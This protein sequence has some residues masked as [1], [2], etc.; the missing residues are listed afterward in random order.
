MDIISIFVTR[1]SVIIELHMGRQHYHSRC[2]SRCQH[3]HSHCPSCVHIGT[4]TLPVMPFPPSLTHAITHGGAWCCVRGT[5]AL[6]LTLPLTLSALSLTL[7]VMRSQR[8]SHTARHALPSIT[9]PCTHS[10]RRLVL[11]AGGAAGSGALLSK[12]RTCL[13]RMLGYFSPSMRRSTSLPPV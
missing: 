11:R 5:S 12:G 2:H 6:S 4:L 8:H 1:F 3:Y 10:R 7:P 13:L 9:H